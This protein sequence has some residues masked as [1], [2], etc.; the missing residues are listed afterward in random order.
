MSKLA[1]LAALS[2]VV[3]FSIRDRAPWDRSRF[4][5][6]PA[7]GDPPP[8]PPPATFTQAQLDGIIADRLKKLTAELEPLKAAA[9]KTAELEATLAKEREE[10]E[11]LGK[12]EAEKARI[13]A[14]K[15]SAKLALD[16]ETALRETKA[17]KELRL[18]AEAKLTD[19][20]K[21]TH[22]QSGLL[23]AKVHGPAITHATQLFALEAEIDLDEKSA[24][25]AVRVGGISYAT[26][27]L[28][29]A[30]W[31]K[32]NPHFAAAPAGGTGQR[33]GGG[34]LG[35]KPLHEQSVESLF[36]AGNALRNGR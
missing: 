9:A 32:A 27:A 25:T 29:A 20:I 30:E 11:L 24:V 4:H 31:L 33:P 34:Q 3:P 36:A 15:A 28:A 19:H 8:P 14:E 23:A 17:E 22:V 12:T 10:R 16:R 1:T 5:P 18:A 7:G 35:G 2:S 13:A 26:V 6:E 21:S